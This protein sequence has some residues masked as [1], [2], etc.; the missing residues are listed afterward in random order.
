ME[1]TFDRVRSVKDIAISAVILAA[2]CICI[3]LPTST[4]VNITGFF[5]IFTGTILF[6]ILQKKQIAPQQGRVFHFDEL[7]AHKCDGDCQCHKPA[8]K[9][10]QKQEE[11]E[12]AWL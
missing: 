11:A 6:L 9:P 7:S 5:L 1:K 2:G 12:L 8:Q 10:A 4:P 3:V